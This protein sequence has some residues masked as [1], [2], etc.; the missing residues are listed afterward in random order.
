MHFFC[1]KSVTFTIFVTQAE[2]KMHIPDGF[3]STPV[4]AGTAGISTAYLAGVIA[5]LKKVLQEKMIP[6]MGLIAAFVFAAQ[7]LNFPIAAGTSGHFLGGVLAAIVL[8]P[9]AGSLV[10]ALV[11]IIQSIFFQ[12]GGITALGANIFNVAIIGTLGGYWVYYILRKLIIR[13][14]F[15]GARNDVKLYICYGIGAWFSVVI[16]SIACALELAISKTIPLKLVL[17]MMASVHAI[18]GIGEAIIT[19]LVISALKKVRPDLIRN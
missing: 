9:F 2:A 10:L 19:I 6:I 3:L 11:L 17:P 16:A 4:W 12:D 15:A 7:M 8:G 13:D 5:H 14:C 1:E 18:I